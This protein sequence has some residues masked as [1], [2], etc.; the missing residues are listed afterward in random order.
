MRKVGF[1]AL[2]LGALAVLQ[3]DGEIGGLPHCFLRF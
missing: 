3:K 1:N 2:A